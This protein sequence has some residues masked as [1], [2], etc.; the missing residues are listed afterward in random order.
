MRVVSCHDCR[1]QKQQNLFTKEDFQQLNMG[2]QFIVNEV[3]WHGC[4]I[5]IIESYSKWGQRIRGQVLNANMSFLKLLGHRRDIPAKSQ[6][7]PPQKFSFPGFEAHI[8]LFGP[9]PF[10]WKTPTQPEDIRTKKFGFGF[11]FL[12][13]RMSINSQSRKCAKNNLDKKFSGAVRVRV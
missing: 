5:L 2:L 8:E 1:L 9:Q 7:I 12:P 10:A 11:L 13:R 3:L 4:M 6:D